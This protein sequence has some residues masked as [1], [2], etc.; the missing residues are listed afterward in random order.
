M[1]CQSLRDCEVGD[2][3]IFE[4]V[5][6]RYLEVP[7]E[8]ALIGVSNEFTTV[9]FKWKFERVDLFVPKPNGPDGNTDFL[10]LYRRVK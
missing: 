10:H 5:T 3:T 9:T 1:I 8:L 7:V 4:Y 6:D 2:Y